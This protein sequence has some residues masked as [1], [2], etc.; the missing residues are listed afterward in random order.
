M[1]STRLG[2]VSRSVDGRGGPS[3]TIVAT[4]APEIH[5]AATRGRARPTWVAMRMPMTEAGRSISTA[6]VPCAM[7]V[8]ISSM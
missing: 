5:S 4:T 2:A 6:T 7:S 3:P 1:A 8:P